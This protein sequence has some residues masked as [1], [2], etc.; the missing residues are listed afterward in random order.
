M[1]S[2]GCEVS[3]RHRLEV[4]REFARPPA[5]RRSGR[6]QPLEREKPGNVGHRQNLHSGYCDAITILFAGI[7]HELPVNLTMH[8]EADQS[9]TVHCA[10]ACGIY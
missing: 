8:P 6:K 4:S 3:R 7:V 2:E 9:A 1:N 10:T 5:G